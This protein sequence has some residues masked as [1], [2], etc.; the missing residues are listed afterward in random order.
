MN[1]LLMRVAVG[2]VVLFAIPATATAHLE[3]PSYWPDPRPDTSITPAAGGEVP[4][5]RS[6]SSSVSAARPGDVRVVCQRNSLTLAKR[7]I[8]TRPQDGYQLRPSQ[9][10][11]QA[12]AQAASR[13]C[14]KINRALKRK[15]RF[16]SIQDAVN[17]S[18]NND[19]IVIMPGR[20]TEPEVARRADQRPE[21]QPVAAAGRPDRPARRRATTTR[22]PA[23][24]TRT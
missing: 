7:S 17:A 18:G 5:I 13:A 8:G 6:L 16:D 11:P 12:L 15:C 21:V 24:T 2:A 10:G 1:G 9:P 22:P 4:K 23:R 14:C 20:Y 3:R 19:R